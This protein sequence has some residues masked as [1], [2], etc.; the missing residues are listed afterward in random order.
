MAGAALLWIQ[1]TKE[2]GAQ[3]V[4]EVNGV[5]T[6]SYPLSEDNSVTIEGFGGGAKLLVIE[7]HVA[8]V[9]KASCPDQLC[10]HQPDIQYQGQTIVCLP[11]RVV[12][13]IEGGDEADVDGIAE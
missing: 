13:S 9:A 11:N 12:I 10:V 2:E 7:D 4:V 3:V 5:K 1:L 6:A 8:T